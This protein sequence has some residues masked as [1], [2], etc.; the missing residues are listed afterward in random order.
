MFGKSPL[1]PFGFGF[2]FAESGVAGSGFAG[3]SRS[4]LKPLYIILYSTYSASDF[5]LG[6]S[7]FA[8]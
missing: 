2:G 8:S 4:F 6:G 5:H 1:P 7:L 3:S